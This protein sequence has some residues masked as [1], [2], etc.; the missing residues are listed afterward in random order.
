MSKVI[1]NRNGETGNIF[2]VLGMAYASLLQEGRR[3]DAEAMSAKV[4]EQQ[5]YEDALNVIAEFVDLQ[6][7]E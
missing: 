4:V 3:H 1:F 7:E 6:E 2:W 5:S